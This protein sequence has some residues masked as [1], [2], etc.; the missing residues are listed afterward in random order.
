[1]VQTLSDDQYTLTL[2]YWYGYHMGSGAVALGRRESGPAFLILFD[3]RAAAE[4]H[5]Q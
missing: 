5:L 2:P 3:D 4:L 1:L